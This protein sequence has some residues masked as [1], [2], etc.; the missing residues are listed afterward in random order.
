YQQAIDDYT[1]AIEFEPTD[2]KTYYNRGILRYFTQDY[3][4]AIADFQQAADLYQQQGKDEDYQE[5]IK[6]ITK[7]KN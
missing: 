1:T 4:A 5:V 3:Q 7:L 2:A 6:M